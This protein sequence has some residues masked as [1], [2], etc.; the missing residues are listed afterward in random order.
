MVLSF[1]INER[2]NYLAQDTEFPL[3]QDLLASMDTIIDQAWLH[4]ASLQLAPS[5]RNWGGV[6][7]HS[8]MI[9]RIYR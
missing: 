1:C 8:S 2:V 3:V 6:S 7:R 9:Q 4:A 5:L